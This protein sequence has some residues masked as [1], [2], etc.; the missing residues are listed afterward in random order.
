MAEKQTKSIY[1]EPGII[2]H[3]LH[4]FF[5]IIFTFVWSRH[6]YLSV[7][8]EETDVEKWSNTPLITDLGRVCLAIH[9]EE[10]EFSALNPCAV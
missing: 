7:S 10:S 9:A 6:Y 1:Y 8:E 3:A 2:L 5:F 4:V